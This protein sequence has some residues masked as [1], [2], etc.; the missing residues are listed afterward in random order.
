MYLLHG[1][2]AGHSTLLCKYAAWGAQFDVDHMLSC[3]HGRFHMLRHNDTWDVIAG[4]LTE[5]CSD[6]STEPHLQQVIG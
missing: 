4:L 3:K 2:T 5:V 1:D 6:V